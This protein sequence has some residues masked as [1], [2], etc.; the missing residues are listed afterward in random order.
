[1]IYLMA[2]LEDNS[3]AI[4]G[5]VRNTYKVMVEVKQMLELL[6]QTIV[7]RQYSATDSRFFCEADPTLHIYLSQDITPRTFLGIMDK[8]V[9]AGGVLMNLIVP[10]LRVI[11]R[12]RQLECGLEEN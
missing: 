7:E 4:I 10:Q 5:S 9:K 8:T 11:S 3:W 12:E 6:V 2:A 1:M